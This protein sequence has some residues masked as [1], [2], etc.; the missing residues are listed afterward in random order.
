MKTPSL[1]FSGTEV[2]VFVRA[3]DEGNS[4]AVLKPRRHGRA[5]LQ[6]RQP[7]DR[8]QLFM[9]LVYR[10]PVRLH[11]RLIDVL[12]GQIERI[13]ALKRRQCMQLDRARRCATTCASRNGSE[14][15]DGSKHS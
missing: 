1:V 5:Q 4:D 12:E 13:S 10:G 2:D 15:T 3:T 6:R 7:V 11:M 8:S 14:N 9:I